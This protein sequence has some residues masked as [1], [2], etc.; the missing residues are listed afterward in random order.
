MAI[1]Q[2]RLQG[3]GLIININSTAGLNGK[4]GLSAYVSSKYAIKGR[5]ESIREELKGTDIKLYQVFPGGMQTDIYHE[6][7]PD[8]INAYMSIEFAIDKVMSNLKSEQPEV[9]LIIYRPN[10]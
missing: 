8:D 6:K 3:E 10:V 4:P 7:V 9:D 2:M 1:K 5:S